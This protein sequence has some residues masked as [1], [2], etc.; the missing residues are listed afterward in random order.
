MLPQGAEFLTSGSLGNAGREP[1]PLSLLASGEPPEPGALTLAHAGRVLPIQVSAGDFPG[2]LRAAADL[3]AD[4]ERVCGVRPSVRI[5]ALG[6]APF[7]QA[8]MGAWVGTLLQK[9]VLDAGGVRPCYLGPPE[10]FRGP[11]RRPPTDDPDAHG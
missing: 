10:T 7:D 5:A 2:V 1:R 6:S 3:A 4:L 11:L 8:S 9:I